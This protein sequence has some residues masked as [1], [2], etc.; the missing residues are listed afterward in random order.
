MYTMHNIIHRTF[1]FGILLCFALSAMGQSDSSALNYLLQR[2][3]V[4]KH[5]DDKKF[6]DHVFVEIGMGVNSTAKG[7]Y[8]YLEV[9]GMQAGG[10][11]G[12]WVTPLHGWRY[13]SLGTKDDK[14]SWRKRRLFAKYHRA[15]PTSI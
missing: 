11:I 12:D 1:C 2:P 4:A 6:G 7:S 14:D 13:Q 10:A 3:P 9:P 8:P 15:Q 5:Y